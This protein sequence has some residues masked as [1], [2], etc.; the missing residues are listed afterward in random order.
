MLDERVIESPL[1]RPIPRDYY[2]GIND[3]ETLDERAQ[4]DDDHDN[5]PAPGEEGRAWRLSE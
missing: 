2:F 3:E 1:A 4:H 5:D